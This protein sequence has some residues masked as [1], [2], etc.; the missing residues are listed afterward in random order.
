VASATVAQAAGNQN[1]LDI[2]TEYKYS[3]VPFVTMIKKSV[4]KYFHGPWLT[5]KIYFNTN[6]FATK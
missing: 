2:T 4:I 1:E 3:R 5:T 6:F